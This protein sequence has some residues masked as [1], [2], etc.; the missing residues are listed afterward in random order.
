MVYSRN[1][2]VPEQEFLTS[3]LGYEREGSAIRNDATAQY[4]APRIERQHDPVRFQI[5][6]SKRSFFFIEL[7]R[8]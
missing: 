5:F 7:V 6:T 8:R 3:E 4:D 2:V 1:V